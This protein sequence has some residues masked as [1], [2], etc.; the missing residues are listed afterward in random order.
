MQLKNSKTQKPLLLKISLDNLFLII[1]QIN[2]LKGLN[3]FI[4]F[5][6]H[7]IF[8]KTFHYSLVK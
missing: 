8:H 6:I 1:I 3:I 7:V 4:V 2:T 5:K